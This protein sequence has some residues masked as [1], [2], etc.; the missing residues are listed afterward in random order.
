[1]PGRRTA[2]TREID[3]YIGARMR[4][5]RLMRGM[6]QGELAKLVGLAF[7]Q[8]QKYESGADRISASRLLDCAVALHTPFGW[9]VEGADSP[10][11]RTLTRRG[12]AAL[13]LHRSI[14]EITEPG[15]RQALRRLVRVLAKSGVGPRQGPAAKALVLESA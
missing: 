15:C 14:G 7:Q 2:H 10:L 12:S 6:S 1:M 11:K 3:R 9:F 8:I 4:E 5:R 13:S